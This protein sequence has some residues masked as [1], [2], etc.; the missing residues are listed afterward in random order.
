M[1]HCKIL[2][3]PQTSSYI[4]VQIKTTLY[5]NTHYC[6]L[7]TDILTSKVSQY[8]YNTYKL[9]I[10]MQGNDIEMNPGP[11]P[12]N[13]SITTVKGNFHQGDPEKFQGKSVG[14][15]CVTNS[16]MAIIYSI[17]L[18]I[19][20]WQP[21]N[22]DEILIIGDILYNKINC[23]HDYL[24]VSDI[25]DIVKVFDQKYSVT[26][27]GELFGQITSSSCDQIGQEIY[28]SIKSMIQENK[29]TTGVLCIGQAPDTSLH[30]RQ[31][32]G[33]ACALLVN[34]N[35]FY[36]F[37]SHSRDSNG[38]IA[39]SGTSVLL[40]FTNINQYCSH[41]LELCFSLNCNYYEITIINVRNLFIEIYL[42]DEE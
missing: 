19:K 11:T 34:M 42:N 36:I 30:S 17:M 10:I 6:D 13:L 16:I 18:P 20:Y 12:N 37:D 32:G 41:I 39:E 26:R 23:P 22:L 31:Q 38:K 3:N 4:L 29:W 33:S 14:K 28:Y 8:S 40:H 35:N 1:K 21:E 7:L 9:T 2:W 25:P 24:L 27:N 15:Q 5:K